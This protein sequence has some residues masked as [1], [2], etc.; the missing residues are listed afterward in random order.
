MSPGKG[1]PVPVPSPT[2]T[3]TSKVFKMSKHCKVQKNVKN[4]INTHGWVDRK[5]SHKGGDDFSLVRLEVQGLSP[6]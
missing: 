5:A 4:V 3:S 1:S 2:P 6:V